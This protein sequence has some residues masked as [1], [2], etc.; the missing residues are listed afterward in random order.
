MSISA[1]WFINVKN[2]LE[3]QNYELAIQKIRKKATEEPENDSLQL[4]LAKTFHLMECNIEALVCINKAISLKPESTDYKLWKL[5]FA[6]LEKRKESEILYEQLKD[7]EGE[8]ATIAI[9]EYF[10]QKM[11]YA[12]SYRFGQKAYEYN[13]MNMDAVILLLKSMD[14]LD[15]ESGKIKKFLESCNNIKDAR[16]QKLRLKILYK[17]N[18]YDECRKIA[19]KISRL[20]PNTDLSQYADEMLRKLR[21][22]ATKKSEVVLENNYKSEDGKE[23]KDREDVLKQTM[24]ELN[25]LI[26]LDDVKVQINMICKKIIFDKKRMDLLKKNSS[27]EENK[28]VNQAS[29]HFV[30]SG[31]PGTGKTTVAR[32]FGKIFYGLGILETGQ[33]IETDR[34]GLVGEY[35]GSTAQKT[36]EMIKKAMGGVLF[37]DEAYSLYSPGGTAQDF[38]MEAIDTL[39]KAVE[40]N[41]DKFIVILAGYKDEMKNLMKAN[42]GLESR[43]TKFV[44]FPDYSEEELLQIAEKIAEENAYSLSDD[45]KQAFLSKIRKS[46]VDDRFGNAR[47]VRNIVNS[48]FEHKA[49]N[50]DLAQ[51]SIEEITILNAE[52]F[53]VDLNENPEEKAERYIKDLQEL[54]GLE[55]V[56]KDISNLIDTINY[57]KEEKKRIGKQMQ[58]PSL[59]MVFQGNPG[60]GKTTVAKLYGKILRELGILAKG[61]FIEATRADLVGQYQGHTASLVREKCKDAY[62][63]ILFVDEAYSLCTDDNDSFGKEAISTLIKEMEDNREKLVVILAGYTR[64]MNDFLNKNSGFKSRISKYLNF[65]D[66]TASEMVRIFDLYCQKDNLTYDDLVENKVKEDMK[67]MELCKD[68]NFGNARDVRKYYESAKTEMYSRV[69]RLG[70]QGDDRRK[71]IETDLNANI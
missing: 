66:Y 18:E 47:T 21:K 28:I 7:C 39:V 30:F 27:I 57:Q 63:G 3:E 53:G 36:Q 58:M 31:N 35:I 40:D 19:K 50:T 54:I 22:T 25:S 44:D 24:Q 46:M 2:L 45:G 59:H 37:I 43:F 26:G 32:M 23:K 16:V 67:K 12:E 20:Y 5:L 42:P 14:A 15:I 65:E 17:K 56:K 11:Q 70:V 52:D 9:G 10:F 68:Q 6:S 38:G 69:Q 61:Q 55:N 29:Y 8:L 41:R 71:I 51:L 13:S 4:L 1:S 49:Y 64:E 34:S 33:L 48:A 62:G 60:T